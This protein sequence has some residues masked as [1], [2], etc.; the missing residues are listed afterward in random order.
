MIC[1]FRSL[2]NR[3]V[4]DLHAQNIW[5]DFCLGFGGQGRVSL[6]NAHLLAHFLHFTLVLMPLFMRAQ[7]W[8][9]VVAIVW[10]YSGHIHF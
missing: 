1:R 9:L 5:I 6:K 10:A 3:F 2:K 4:S 7:L 8:L